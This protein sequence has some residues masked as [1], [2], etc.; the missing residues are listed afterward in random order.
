MGDGM[1]RRRWIAGAIAAVVVAALAVLVAVGSGHSEAKPF[2]YSVDEARLRCTGPSFLPQ[3]AAK[4][5]LDKPPPEDWRDVQDHP[6][7]IFADTEYVEI[8]LEPGAQESVTFKRIDFRVRHR[9]RQ[10][11][12]LLYPSC[13]EMVPGWW[14]A[15]D[16]DKTPPAFAITDF[17]QETHVVHLPWNISLKAPR[18]IYLV[19]NSSKCDCAW[20]AEI[21]WV[22][23][24]QHGTIQ[25][26]EGDKDFEI[27]HSGGI[28]KYIA[29]ADSWTLSRP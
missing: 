15:T 10:Q 28:P 3:Q 25:V 26:A 1:R 24:E 13:Y 4:E 29:G 5:I 12:D 27:T 21:A 23:G 18:T 9:Q 16:F 20:R 6:G 7:S 8:H 14:I 2:S 22:S 11:G 17:P 19:A